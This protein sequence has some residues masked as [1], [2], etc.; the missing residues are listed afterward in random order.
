MPPAETRER[1][2]EVARRLFHEQGYHATGVSTILREADVRS[3]SL[4]YFFESK[5]AL[6]VEVLN[7]YLEALHPMVMGPAEGLTD[8]PVERVFGLLD[9]YRTGLGKTGCTLGCP[10]GNLALEL[11]DNHPQIRT[12]IDQNFHNW[13][14]AVRKWLDDAGDRLPSSLDREALARF[15]LTVMEGGVMQSRAA[16]SLEPMDRSISQLR[17]YFNHLEAAAKREQTEA[18]A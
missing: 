12:L 15:I 13:A 4:Y 6:L 1:I 16:G 14:A 7:W 8:D 5:E 11:G 17:E 10:I 9:L 2:L 18:G 3:G